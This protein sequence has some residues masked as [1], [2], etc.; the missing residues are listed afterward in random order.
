MENLKSGTFCYYVDPTQDISE[1]GGF[2]PSLVIENEPGHRLML[3]Q[4][5]LAA[6]WVW[7]DTIEQAE[8]ICD[9]TNAKMG[10]DAKRAM[11]IVCSSMR[12]GH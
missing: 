5:P 11:R 1:H 8:R 6:P 9:E 4:G 10:I 7:G 2:V 12:A 3:G